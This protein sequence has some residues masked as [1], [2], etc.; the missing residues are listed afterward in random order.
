MEEINQW[1]QAQFTAVFGSLFESSSWVAE[2]TW[3]NRPFET[4]D[5]LF[6]YMEYMVY[7]A[8]EALQLR[9]LRAYPALAARS[10]MTKD[11]VEASLILEWN[12]AYF[13]QFGFPFIIA[14]RG[15]TT[16]N[17]HLA[18]QKRLKHTMEIEMR[19]ALDEVCKIAHTRLR[20]WCNQRDNKAFETS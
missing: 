2:R 4:L 19:V 6:H 1:N 17:I 7:S 18:I 10:P 16:E 15:L 8:E 11:T 13:D 5:H 20:L 9:L 3:Y 14:E 12:E